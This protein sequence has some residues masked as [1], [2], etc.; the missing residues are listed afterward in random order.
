MTT[1]GFDINKFRNE[2]TEK[3]RNPAPAAPSAAALPRLA[4]QRRQRALES[5]RR[6]AQ[7]RPGLN[8][9]SIRGG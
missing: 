6:S 8:L 4:P 9:G 2:L 1:Q 5:L 7:R 3:L